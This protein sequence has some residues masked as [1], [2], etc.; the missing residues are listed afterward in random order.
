M[1]CDTPPP[2]TESDDSA[3]S[4]CVSILLLMKL[5]LLHFSLAG[6]NIPPAGG[7]N[8]LMHENRLQ[9][10][11]YTAGPVVVFSRDLRVF[12]FSPSESVCAAANKRSGSHFIVMEKC[13]L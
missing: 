4:L 7:M 3:V 10:A 13:L 2:I 11:N 8:H 5:S 1:C 6:R 9:A 12:G